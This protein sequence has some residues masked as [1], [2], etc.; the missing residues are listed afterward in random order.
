MGP[1]ESLPDV[2]SADD[3]PCGL[4]TTN[5]QGT[6]LAVNPLF[7]EWVGRSRQALANTCRLQD[8]L[9]MGSRM[10]MQTHWM[11]LMQM[12]GSIAEVKLEVVRA[13]GSSL[14]VLMNAVSSERIGQVVYNVA[15][16]LARD[17]D[18]YEKELLLAQRRLQTMV[19]EEKRLLAQSRD[20]A[21]F[22]EQ[23]VGIVSHDLRNPLS[24]IHLGVSALMRTSPTSH[25]QRMLDRI[26]RSTNRA[27]A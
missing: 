24:A 3:A 12:Q 15:M 6:L 17:R 16:F 21:Q 13:D 4:L 19:E 20:R 1:S 7:C 18:K 23:M 9:S 26:S 27:T 25:Q 10:F 5:I 14:P 11:P 2:P 22:A 8:L